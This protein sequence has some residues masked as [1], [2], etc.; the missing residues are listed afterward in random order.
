[1][2][3]QNLQIKIQQTSDYQCTLREFKIAELVQLIEIHI[4]T[5]KREELQYL[6]DK[7]F[8]LFNWFCFILGETWVN[9]TSNTVTF[10]RRYVQFTESC[11]SLCFP[12]LEFS[13]INSLVNVMRQQLRHVQESATKKL[14]DPKT[15]EINGNFLVGELLPLVEKKV[16][17]GLGHSCP[18]LQQL[19]KDFAS[20][21]PKSVTKYSTTVYI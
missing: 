16:C 17:A 10:A 1:M 3:F 4:F 12:E 15:I 13:V 19:G 20:L 6:C 7:F 14:F 9:L 11:L 5:R 21:A 8:L 2:L 18:E